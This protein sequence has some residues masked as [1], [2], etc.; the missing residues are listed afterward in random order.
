MYVLK[1][2]IA[3]GYSYM[4]NDTKGGGGTQQTQIEQDVMK[5]ET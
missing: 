1:N 5:Y 4:K 2:T 3:V